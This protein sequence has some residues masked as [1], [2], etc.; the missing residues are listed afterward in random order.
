M[1]YSIPRPVYRVVATHVLVPIDGSPQSWAAL[2]HAFTTFEGERITTLTVVD[3][4][5]E[6]S[7][8]VAPGGTRARDEHDRGID[9]ATAL[10]DRVRERAADAGVVESTDSDHEVMIGKPARAILCH[11]EETDVDHV[12]IGSHGRTGLSRILLGSVAESVARRS[13]IPVTV[14]R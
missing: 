3:P 13:P 14:V 10:G 4:L 6:L 5:D 7:G 1:D 12:V 8:G 9:S 11:A 2:D